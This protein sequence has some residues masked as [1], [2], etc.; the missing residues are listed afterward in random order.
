VADKTPRTVAPAPG[1]AIEAALRELATR[2]EAH[3]VLEAAAAAEQLGAAIE[4]S[5][6]APLDELTR[7]RLAPLVEHCTALAAKSNVKL[8]ATLARFGV[9]KRALRAYGAE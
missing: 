1:E 3:E 5:S 2:L 7:A 4:A 6:S 8:A 9:G